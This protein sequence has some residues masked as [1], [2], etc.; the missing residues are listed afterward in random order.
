MTPV[1]LLGPAH[2]RCNSVRQ[3]VSFEAEWL[4]PAALGPAG[5]S[6]LVEFQSEPLSPKLR[7]VAGDRAKH[8][9]M[10]PARR[11]RQIMLTGHDGELY[12]MPLRQLNQRLVLSRLAGESVSM[13]GDDDVDPT[14]LG[15]GKELLVARFGACLRTRS[16]RCLHKPAR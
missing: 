15:V 6:Q 5:P 16:N 14:R 13:P 2:S 9:E 1:W 8:A 11:R 7:L 3:L 4:V 10:Q 12:A